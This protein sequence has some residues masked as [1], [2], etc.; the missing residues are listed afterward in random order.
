M[1][2]AENWIIT[3]KTEKQLVTFENKIL[4]KIYGPT[5]ENGSWRIKRNKEIR[6]LYINQPDIVAEIKRTRLRWAGHILSYVEKVHQISETF[7]KNNQKD[8]DQKE[9]PKA[10]GGIKHKKI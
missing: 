9:D 3:K 10:D 1:Y 8:D 2:G 5:S 4:R 6:D 7:G